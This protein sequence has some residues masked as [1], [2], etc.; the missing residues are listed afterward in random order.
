MRNS[1]VERC[2]DFLSLLIQI[3]ISN[4]NLESYT[5]EISIKYKTKGKYLYEIYDEIK[6]YIENFHK[7]KDKIENE[8]DLYSLNIIGKILFPLIGFLYRSK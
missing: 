3:D 1:F 4:K 8:F 5:S 2:I 6:G 7:I